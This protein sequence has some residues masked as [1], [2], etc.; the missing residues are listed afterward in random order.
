MYL[1][2]TGV[3][4]GDYD[5]VIVEEE[6]ARVLELIRDGI[7][8]LRVRVGDARIIPVI[9]KMHYLRGKDKGQQEYQNGHELSRD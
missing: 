9:C 4:I 1:Q 8:M 2:G 7:S 6:G 5:P 3:D